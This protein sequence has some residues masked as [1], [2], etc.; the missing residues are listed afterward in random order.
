[1]ISYLSYDIFTWYFLICIFYFD[2][3]YWNL[4]SL[5]VCLEYFNVAMMRR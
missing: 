3:I 4:I 1:M 2:M 5:S